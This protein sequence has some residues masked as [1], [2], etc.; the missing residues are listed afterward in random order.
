M[1]LLSFIF[2]FQ[3]YYSLLEWR[4]EKNKLSKA[5]LWMLSNEFKGIG[6]TNKNSKNAYGNKNRQKNAWN[7][8]KKRI[9]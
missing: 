1:A 9:L 7:Y 2:D 5:L 3:K 4:V 6:Y 8:T